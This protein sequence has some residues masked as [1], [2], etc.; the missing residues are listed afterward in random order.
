MPRTETPVEKRQR[1]A[2]LIATSRNLIERAERANRDFTAAEQR[3]ADGLD[4]EITT[5]TTDIETQEAEEQAA[6]DGAP[7]PG[8]RPHEREAGGPLA[9]QFRERALNNSRA[10]IHVTIPR[11]TSGTAVRDITTTSGGGLVPSTF[12]NQLLAALTENSG[13]IGAGARMITSETGET[14]SFPVATG[15]SSAEIVPEGDTIPSSDPSFTTVQ[16]SPYK[17]AFLVQASR[18]V[19]EDTTFDLEGYLAEQ[20]GTALGNA[21]GAHAIGGTGSG[22]PTGLLSDVTVGVTGADSTDSTVPTADELIA[23]AHSVIAPYATRG[24][25]LMNSATLGTVRALKTDAGDYAFTSGIQGNARGQVGTL[26]NRP[27]FLDP[28]MPAT[29][30]GALSVLFGDFSRYYVRQVRS[31]RFERSD[32]FAFDQDLISWRGIWRVDGR[33]ADTTGAIKAFEGGT[34]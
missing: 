10:P 30:A 19:I 6:R 15:R 14:M 4:G 9:E 8:P 34:A 32:Q 24:A 29:G 20:S 23:L 22:Q 11:I 28:N 31:M 21:F 17:Y 18:E 5:L 26:L 7:P 25:W 1:R 16:L 2:Q 13:V 3:E 33:L 12:F 27:V